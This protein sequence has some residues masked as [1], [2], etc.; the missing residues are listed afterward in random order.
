MFKIILF[1]RAGT[2]IKSLIGD[3]R[4]ELAE[5]ANEDAKL[6]NATSFRFYIRSGT[7]WLE[8]ML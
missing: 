5:R 8:A 1:S 3:D 2:T 4:Q 7:L 6:L